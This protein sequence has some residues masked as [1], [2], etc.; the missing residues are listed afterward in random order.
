MSVFLLFASES[1]AAI[2]LDISLLTE[3]EEEKE[4]D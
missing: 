4:V 1:L 2:T 3:Q